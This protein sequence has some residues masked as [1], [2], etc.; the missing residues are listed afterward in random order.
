M[1]EIKSETKARSQGS[2][3]S[4][5]SPS[6]LSSGPVRVGF[7]SASFTVVGAVCCAGSVLR[8]LDITVIHPRTFLIWRFETGVF[9]SLV[10]F[11]GCAGCV[12]FSLSQF[13]RIQISVHIKQVRLL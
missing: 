4:S 1:R 11:A 8:G 2:S 6:G 12:R 5:S 13:S 3:S 9:F 7:V 10:L